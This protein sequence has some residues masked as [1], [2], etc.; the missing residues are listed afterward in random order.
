VIA[1]DTQE[2]LYIDFLCSPVCR[3]I[4]RMKARETDIEKNNQFGGFLFTGKKGSG[5]NWDLMLASH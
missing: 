1:N 3:D 2:K 5:N 4:D